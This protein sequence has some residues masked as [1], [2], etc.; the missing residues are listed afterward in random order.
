MRHLL[1]IGMGAGNP[2]Y[3]TVQA[4]NALRSA[5]VLFI[6]DK[7]PDKEELVRLRREICRRHAPDAKFRTVELV[8][9][10]RD[11]APSDYRQAVLDWHSRRAELYETALRDHLSEGERGAFL[12]WGDPSLYDSILRIMEQVAA[13][14]AVAFDYEVIPGISSVQ[15]L[16]ARHRITLNRIG[17]P[18]HLTPGRRLTPDA[19]R[20]I[21][22]QLVV[23]DGDCAFRC[24]P[25]DVEIFWGAYLGTPDEILIRGPLGEVSA[26]IVEA[27]AEARRRK[28]WIMDTYL[29][30]KPS[31]PPR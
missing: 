30:R 22:D 18:V 17:E 20:T 26:S 25:A 6:T 12:V 1:I 14:G 15:A 3:I 23:L 28:G 5:H 4:I 24:A 7:G 8:D 16:A 21:G 29:L 9:P 31:D 13:R 19:V 27:R 10:V 2:D 11:R